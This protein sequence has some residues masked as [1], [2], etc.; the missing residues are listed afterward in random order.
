MRLYPEKLADHLQQKLLPVYLVSG[1]EPLLLQECCDQIRQKARAEN[2]NEREI[3]E[4]GVSNFNWQDILHSAS[5]MSLFADRK[6]IEL[7]LPSGK[8]GAEGSKALCE[9]LDIASGDDVLLIV[10]GKIDKQST[11]SKWYK[12]LDKA[13]VTVQVWP[14]DAK[15]LPRWLQQRVRN[16]G[17]SIDDDALR[18]LCER[19]EGNLLAAV[20]EV[21][22]LKLLAADSK[23][24]M[25][26][27]TEAVSD[28]A[29]Y[30]LFDMADNALK[31]NAS[32]SLRMLYGLRAAGTEPPVVLWALVREI[33][34]LYE[35]Q[36]DCDSGQSTQ[37]ALSSRRVWQNRMPLMQAALTRHNT[38]S[39][40]LL[41]EQAAR[42]DGS[43]KGFADGKPWDNL[44]RLVITLC[45]AN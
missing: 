17:M 28:N 18:L 20:Q 4:G 21:E 12:A 23:I 34:T 2:C 40:S 45:R 43:I 3:I 37:Q 9:Y 6:L 42:A 31:G 44:S 32:V 1:D 24:T 29:R 27:V 39:L 30:N 22:K 19:M 15:N 14:V 10:S 13:G 5:N 41:L 7:R 38:H 16:A 11:N 36:L 8:P 33:R 26:T 25:Q 35:A